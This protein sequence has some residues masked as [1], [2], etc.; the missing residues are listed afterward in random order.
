MSKIIA[1]CGI[2]CTDCPAYIAT[3]KDDDELRVKTAKE[4]SKMFHAD[5][6]QEH[7]NC[8]GCNVEGKRIQHC[9][10]CEIRLCSI[11]KGLENCSQCAD[12]ACS[13]LEEFFRMV[14]D[15][16]VTLDAERTG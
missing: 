1:V 11:G 2:T 8:D 5:I 6:R 9:N 13:K 7:I 4:W 15:A 3:Q 16:K 14:P 12:Y 10:E